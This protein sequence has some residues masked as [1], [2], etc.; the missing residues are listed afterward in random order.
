M[1]QTKA[2]ARLVLMSAP[3]G[4]AAAVADVLSAAYGAGDIASVIARFS[5]GS[6]NEISARARALVPQ[7]RERNVAFLLQDRAALAAQIRADGAHLSD[8]QT[9]RDGASILKPS[10]IAG[11]GGLATRHDAMLAAESGADYV[12][13]GEPDAAGKRPSLEA[14]AERVGWWAEIF[15][16]PCVAYAATFDEISVLTRAGADFVALADALWCDPARARTA[17][18]EALSRIS[19]PEHAG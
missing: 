6:D 19:A 11:A 1:N 18:A 16:I 12:M 4:E 14:V 10:L 8:P 5:P 17:I 15:E 2:V 3:I 9:L 7:A 13:F